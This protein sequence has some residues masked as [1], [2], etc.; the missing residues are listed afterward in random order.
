MIV[1]I[2]GMRLYFFY[3]K[4]RKR[5]TVRDKLYNYFLMIIL[6]FHK[7]CRILFFSLN[8]LFLLVIIN[9]IYSNKQT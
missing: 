4:K 1:Y 2:L 9:H 6:I 8:D 7:K 5:L 3:G